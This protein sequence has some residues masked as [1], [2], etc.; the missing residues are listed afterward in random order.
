MMTYIQQVLLVRV[1]HL[2]EESSYATV[3]VRPEIADHHCD[4]VLLKSYS[5]E[6]LAYNLNSLGSQ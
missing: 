4:K 5:A 3:P 2:I 1:M 6:L